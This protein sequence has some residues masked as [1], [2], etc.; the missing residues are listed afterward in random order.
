M[1]SEK[2]LREKDTFVTSAVFNEEAIEITFLEARHQTPNRMRACTEVFAVDSPEKETILSEVQTLLCDLLD[3]VERDARE[4]EEQ[5][6]PPSATYEKIMSDL[7]E[8][9]S[10][11]KESTLFESDEEEQGPVPLFDEGNR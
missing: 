5:K 3:I 9:I 10:L 6:T 1:I 2:D 11:A 4:A 8:T 7:S